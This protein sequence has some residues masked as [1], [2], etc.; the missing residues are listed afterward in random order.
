M[1][2]LQDTVHRLFVNVLRAGERAI[3]GDA[4]HQKPAGTVAIRER[5]DASPNTLFQCVNLVPRLNT[6][7]FSLEILPL[8]IIGL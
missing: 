3:V 2:R 5:R 8:K 4:E 6:D 1:Q 7:F